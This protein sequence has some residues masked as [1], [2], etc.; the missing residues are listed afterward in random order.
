MK[1]T[2]KGIIAALSAGQAVIVVARG[3]SLADLGIYVGNKFVCQ[4]NSFARKLE[5]NGLGHLSHQP[6]ENQTYLALT[7]AARKV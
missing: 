7:F 5:Q 1:T 6:L 2:L 4:W 3:T